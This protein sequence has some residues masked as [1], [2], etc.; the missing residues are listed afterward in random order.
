V[1][2]GGCNYEIGLPEAPLE[3]IETRKVSAFSLPQFSSRHKK[4]EG[5]TSLKRV[6][7]DKEGFTSCSKAHRNKADGA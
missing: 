5:N 2:E 3:Q 4:D 1:A 6:V 7:S